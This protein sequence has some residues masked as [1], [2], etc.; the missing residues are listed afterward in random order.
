MSELYILKEDLFTTYCS[1][2]HQETAKA[3]SIYEL[4]KEPTPEYKRYILIER[5]T[6][7]VE[8]LHVRKSTFKKLFEKI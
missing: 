4:L 6:K 5:E 3:G 2:G 7:F 1:D 8:E